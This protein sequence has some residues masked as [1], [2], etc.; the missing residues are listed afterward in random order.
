MIRRLVPRP[1]DHSRREV[2]TVHGVALFCEQQ[3]ECSGSA[4]EVGDPARRMRKDGSEEFLPRAANR[5]IA[6]PV[7]GGLIEDVSFAVPRV[8]GVHFAIVADHQVDLVGSGHVAAAE[9]DEAD[10]DE[11]CCDGGED[12]QRLGREVLGGNGGYVLER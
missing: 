9:P 7:V 8:D 12:D 4:P 10:A 3:C 1:F 5:R 11:P 6:Q 2:D